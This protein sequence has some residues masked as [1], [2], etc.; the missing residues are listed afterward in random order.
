MLGLREI[1]STAMDSLVVF[2][3][4]ELHQEVFRE[5]WVESDS[6]RKVDFWRNPNVCQVEVVHGRIKAAFG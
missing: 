4:Y 2:P 6:K 1:N 3:S 5:D